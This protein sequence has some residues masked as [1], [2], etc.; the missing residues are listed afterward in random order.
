MSGNISQEQGV[1]RVPYGAVS[2]YKAVLSLAQRIQISQIDKSFLETHSIASKNETKLIS[3]LKAL[4]LI[5]E[6]GNATPNLS[7]L[8]VVGDAYKENLKEIVIEGY[9]LLLSKIDLGMVTPD[10]IINTVVREYEASRTS[11]QQAVKIFVYLADEAGIKISEQLDSLRIKQITR[12]VTKKTPKTEPKKQVK[13]ENEVPEDVEEFKF[14][15]VMIWLPKN[16]AKDA[17]NKAKKMI[18]IYLGIED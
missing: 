11:A 15:D 2:W 17:W 14:G 16:G 4:N 9:S 5:N 6:N 1:K 18:D 13:K 8:H 7:K 12:S 3:G 10:D